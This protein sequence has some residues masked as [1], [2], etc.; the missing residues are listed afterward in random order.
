MPEEKAPKAKKPRTAKA[1]KAKEVV[2]EPTKDVE[3]V[4]ENTQK[5]A[6]PDTAEATETTPLSQSDLTAM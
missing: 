4:A 5:T 1:D 2:D 6:K 3:M